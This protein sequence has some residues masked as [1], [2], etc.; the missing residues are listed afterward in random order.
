MPQPVEP[1]PPAAMF[2]A[3][4][5]RPTLV[6]MV[7]TM[8]AAWT[9]GV[10]LRLLS[11]PRAVIVALYYVVVFGGLIRTALQASVRSGSGRFRVDFGWWA[12]RADLLRAV[13]LGWLAAMAGA[14]A[15]A[16]WHG[17]PTSNTGFGRLIHPGTARR[18]MVALPDDDPDGGGRGWRQYEGGATLARPLLRS[19]VLRGRRHRA[20][21]G[22]TRFAMAD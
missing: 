3:D 21:N 2:P 16:A 18:L 5:I 12:R 17:H 6:G 11:T 8:L 1:Q 9:V 20:A 14:L 22:A 19:F 13:T 10:T 15:V 4:A 7:T